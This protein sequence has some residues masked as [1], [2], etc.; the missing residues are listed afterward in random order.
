L[1][2]PCLKGISFELISLH[3]DEAISA[4]DLL[5]VKLKASQDALGVELLDQPCH[6]TWDWAGAVQHYHGYVTGFISVQDSVGDATYTLTCESPLTVLKRSRQSRHFIYQP[7][8][9]IV[10][11]LI[12]KSGATLLTTQFYL[13]GPNPEREFTAQHDETDLSFF[14][15]I[16]HES[17]WF[18][19]LI[20]SDEGVTLHVS[21]HSSSLPKLP[22]SVPF[23]PLSQGT[24]SC[25]S[26]YE[27][28][29]AQ[30]ERAQYSLSAKSDCMGIRAGCILTLTGHPLQ[31]WNQSYTVVSV[32]HR[33]DEK[34]QALRYQNTLSLLPANFPYRPFFEP[35]DSSIHTFGISQIHS[36]DD[37]PML[38]EQ[39][40][41]ILKSPHT[42]ELTHP[43]RASTIYS[44]NE[45]GLHFPLHD[46]A[47][48]MVGYVNGHPDRPVILGSLFNDEHRNVVNAD[49]PRQNR[50]VTQSG[51][52]LLLD[53]T[54]GH[55]K[56]ALHTP[57]QNHR[58]ILDGTLGAEQIEWVSETGELSVKISKGSQLETA[59]HFHLTADQSIDIKAKDN[60][61]F[62]SDE[63]HLSCEAAQDIRHRAGRNMSWHADQDMKIR[64]DGS[65]ETAVQQSMRTD[66]Q[67]GDYVLKLGTGSLTQQVQQNIQLNTATGDI[68][69]KTAQASV[70]LT[71]EGS[72]I[73]SAKK[74]ILDAMS[75]DIHNASATQEN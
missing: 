65:S 58:F 71:A 38:S 1:E 11:A 46:Q 26:L 22:H 31:K 15:R 33:M 28:S 72:L 74:I 9:Q 30:Q 24:K 52:T 36:K 44:G 2:I 63:A 56:I 10:K 35:E 19:A 34:G 54:P 68:L 25:E 51:H 8:S 61:Q 70:S 57:E 17:A 49:N 62:A 23:Q 39:G 73:F 55:Q 12:D 16:L 66:I 18:Y 48:V 3:H 20:H 7:L 69:L 47:Q 75:I 21:D 5:E 43:I 37:S 29:L 14:E 64:V 41:Y 6:L 40:E 67:N 42:G 45:Y 50:L 27:I 13:N 59:D 53:D 60:I 4:S 32:S